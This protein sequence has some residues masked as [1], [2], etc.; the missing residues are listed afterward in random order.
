MP[1]EKVIALSVKALHLDF[2]WLGV[3]CRLGAALPE[4]VKAVNQE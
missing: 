2:I 4:F 1:V 3:G